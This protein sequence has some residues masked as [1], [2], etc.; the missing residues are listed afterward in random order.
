MLRTHT[1][2]ELLQYREKHYWKEKDC[3]SVFDQTCKGNIGL[4][5]ADVSQKYRIVCNI[6]LTYLL[7]LSVVTHGHAKGRNQEMI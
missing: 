3:W 5:L 2:D 7:S 4:W 1:T 6:Q